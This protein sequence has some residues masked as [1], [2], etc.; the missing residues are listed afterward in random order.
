M[1]VINRFKVINSRTYLHCELIFGLIDCILLCL[2]D[3]LLSQVLT[4]DFTRYKKSEGCPTMTAGLSEKLEPL[5]C[6]LSFH[7]TAQS[8]ESKSNG[9]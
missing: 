9:K 6:L 8:V 1:H 2:S 5:H 7:V 3:Q 4:F